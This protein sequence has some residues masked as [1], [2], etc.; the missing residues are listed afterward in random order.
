MPDPNHIPPRFSATSWILT[1]LAGTPGHHRGRSI[2]IIG[3]MVALIGWLDY[4]TGIRISLVLFYLVPITLSVSWLGWRAGCATAVISVV[5]RTVSDL[6]L[7]P[8]RFPVRAFCNRLA[9]LGIYLILIWVV[10]AL[11]S[12]WRELDQRVRLRTA[13]LEQA[14]RSRDELQAQLFEI[15]R[16]ERSAIGHDLHDGLGQH[17]T[18]TAMAANLLAARLTEAR[19]P[20]VAGAQN[21]V[22]MLQEAIAQTR[23][24]ARG[25]L[26]AAI[27]PGELISELEELAAILSQE[28]RVECRFTWRGPFDGLDAAISSHLFYIAQEAARNALRHARPSRVEI[29]LLAGHGGLELTVTD[30][31]SGR[32]GPGAPATGMGLRIMAHRAGIIG[33]EFS[34]EPVSPTGTR[35]RCRVP[36]PNPAPAVPAP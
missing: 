15:S 27:E 16:R 32:R 12:L 10:H 23:E 14:L 19:Q 36:L 4:I 25:L 6:A 17:L 13:D 24:I 29:S 31:G 2:A 26:L 22:R 34:I 30:N 9:D 33:G 21:I 3:A 35:V 7:A 18:A 28:S 8:Y 5:A 11:I 1:Q 20:M